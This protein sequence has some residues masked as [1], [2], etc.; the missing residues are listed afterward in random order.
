[1]EAISRS[2]A[3]A[4]SHS[5]IDT[6]LHPAYATRAIG[7]E[8]WRS[9]GPIPVG[10]GQELALKLLAKNPALSGRPR[11]SAMTIEG[12]RRPG[13]GAPRCCRSGAD[14]KRVYRHTNVRMT[15]PK[16]T[17]KAIAAK[18]FADLA[19]LAA[20]RAASAADQAASLEL[21]AI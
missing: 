16:A 20:S 2:R 7:S 18:K 10:G 9:D 21:R 17:A 11:P 1:M 12:R 19:L 13:G 14:G 15:D 5:V 3:G 4:D 8:A 6:A